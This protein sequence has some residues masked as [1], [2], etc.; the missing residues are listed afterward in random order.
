MAVGQGVEEPP[1]R[2]EDH[3]PG[4][5]ECGDAVSGY[6]H[7]G[8]SQD[9]YEAREKLYDTAVLIE[10]RWPGEHPELCRDLRDLADTIT[11]ENSSE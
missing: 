1:A 8:L 5:R 6:R 4:L 2:H 10:E 7:S 3:L 11:E 9:A